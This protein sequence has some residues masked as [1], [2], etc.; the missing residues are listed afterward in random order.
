MKILTSLFIFLI[1]AG[2]AV[3]LF[4]L[5]ACSDT[6]DFLASNNP[7]YIRAMKLLEENQ[8]EEA[9][10]G[11]RKSLRLT[12][13]TYDAHLQLAMLCDDHLRQP[14]KALYHYQMFIDN[15]R[16]AEKV[17]LAR[18]S[19]K[20]LT[21][22][23]TVSLLEEFPELKTDGDNEEKKERIETLEDHKTTLLNKL[24]EVNAELVKTRR[25]LQKIRSSTRQ[26]LDPETQQANKGNSQKADNREHPE[27]QVH[28][29]EKGD[30]LISIS[31]QYYDSGTYWEELLKVNDDVL[32]GD[33]S[34]K[35]GTEMTIPS[36]QKIKELQDNDA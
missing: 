32:D 4:L 3:T 1:G 33:T 31:R 10:E 18:Q 24:K 8:F 21:R 17:A 34:L 30:T 6:K 35:I 27:S 20:E 7:Y 29:V 23:F 15:S 16:D 36:R 11:F 22:E 25:Q 14:L 9:A 26:T 19:L 13:D 12:P 2:A 28:K 5:P